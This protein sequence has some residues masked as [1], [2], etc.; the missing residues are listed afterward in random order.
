VKIVW[1]P[2]SLEH[3]KEL[4]QYIALD[5]VGAAEKWVD[6]LFSLVEGLADNP[7][8]GRV[9]P[10]TNQ[11]LIRELIFRKSFRVVYKLENQK[12]QILIVKRFS[13]LLKESEIES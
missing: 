3:V 13:Q 11:P 2:L 4:A 1:S 9:V 7:E 6:D 12:I 8:K 10:E 5:K